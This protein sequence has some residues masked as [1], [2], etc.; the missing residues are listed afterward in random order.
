MV[1]IHYNRSNIFYNFGNKLFFYAFARIIADHYN[2]SLKL[3]QPFQIRRENETV[4]FPFGELERIDSK[5][6]EYLITDDTLLEKSFEEIIAN[7]EGKTVILDGHFSNYNIYKPYKNKIR[8][9]YKDITLPSDNENDVIILLR[10]S[11]IDPKYKTPDEYYIN[12]LKN[13]NFNKLYISYD[14][15][16][17]HV[18]LLKE[19][20]HYKPTILHYNIVDLFKF[21]TSK[22]TIISGKGTFCFWSCF[23]SNAE[24]IYWPVSEVGPNHSGD[25]ILNLNVDDESRYERI[26]L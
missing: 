5:G 20:G 4:D 24:K 7:C 12:I 10:D 16:D 23:L 25:H 3:P 8:E 9:F 14:H 11:N 13:L 22:K 19:I 26:N 6:P 21:I 2:Y 18:S 15:S 1:K 17:K